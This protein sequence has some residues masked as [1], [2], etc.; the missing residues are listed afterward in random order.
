[1]KTIRTDTTHLEKKFTLIELLVVIAIIAILASMLLPALNNAKQKALALECRNK[2]SMIGKAHAQ[3]LNDYRDWIIAAH[4]YRNPE[5]PTWNGSRY[6][7]AKIAYYTG[8]NGYFIPN[9]LNLN[10]FLKADNQM[11][12][13]TANPLPNDAT[14]NLGWN[15]RWGW[16]NENNDLFSIAGREPKRTVNVKRPSGVSLAT[17]AARYVY[18]GDGGYLPDSP[19]IIKDASNSP[20]FPHNSI[21]NHLFLDGHVDG[22]SFREA[23]STYVSGMWNKTTINFLD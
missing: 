2:L 9:P 3:Y 21:G 23:R 5:T 4:G 19:M 7:F 1:M 10:D 22:I 15:F 11:R 18:G 14:P 8:K 20:L 6:W 13:C 12:T 16:I 17:D